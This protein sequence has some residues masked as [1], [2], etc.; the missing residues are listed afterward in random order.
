MS[1]AGRM[2]NRRIMGK[3]SFFELQDSHG[4]V[5]V[6][7]SRDDMCPG[8]D[9]EMYNTV[10]KKLLDM[11]DFVGVEGYVFRTQTGEISV[12]AQS[13][14]L[15]SKSLQKTILAVFS[16]D[17]NEMIGPMG[18]DDQA[19]YIQPIGAMPYTITFENKSTA[20]APANEVW[21]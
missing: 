7:V 16:Y 12:H 15:L 1:I 3:A 9:K 19:H 13:L 14:K 8:E 6:Y 2:M 11:G 4:R 5:Q 21:S 18:P 10:F 20:T 17:P